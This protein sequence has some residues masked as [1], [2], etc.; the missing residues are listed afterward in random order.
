[1]AVRPKDIYEGRKKSRT[2]A[3]MLICCALL[4]LALVV[5]LFFGLRRYCVYDENGD[6]T[7]VLPFSQE[8]REWTQG[9][10]G[11]P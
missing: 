11:I 8:A 3:K 1:M 7:L 6:A 9:E 5:G 2:T 4:L 10:K